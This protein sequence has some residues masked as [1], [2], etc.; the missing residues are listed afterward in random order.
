MK[1]KSLRNAD[2]KH[3]IQAAKLLVEGFKQD[4]PEA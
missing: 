4:W 2:E 3:I 1:I